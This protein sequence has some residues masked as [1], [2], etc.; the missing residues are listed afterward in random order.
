MSKLTI[1]FTY[2]CCVNASNIESEEIQARRH[3]CEIPLSSV[4]PGVHLPPNPPEITHVVKEKQA[5]LSRQLL[6]RWDEGISK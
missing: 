6:Q 3:E 5:N 1:H 2:K 4:M